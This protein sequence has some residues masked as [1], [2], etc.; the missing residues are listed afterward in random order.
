MAVSNAA[1]LVGKPGRLM[2]LAAQ[3]IHRL[4]LDRKQLSTAVF[5]DRLYTLGRLVISYAG[6]RY[7]VIPFKPLLT[8]VAALLY[9]L[10]PIDLIP[11]ALLGFGLADDL[12]VL[13]WVYQ[14]TQQEL[15]KFL[16][17]EQAELPSVVH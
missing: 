2:H 10:N 5:R 6:G 11:D 17:W 9:F 14:S 13:T 4:H 12:A 15:D 16:Q 7:R 8:I 1:R 3:L